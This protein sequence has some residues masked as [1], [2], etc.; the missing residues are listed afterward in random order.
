MMPQGTRRH[1]WKGA[2][3]LRKYFETFLEVAGVKTSF[4]K[5]L[6][7]HSQGVEDS[8]N[9]PTTEMLLEEYLKATDRLTILSSDEE[10]VGSTVQLQKQVAELKEKSKEENWE[11]EQQRKQLQDMAREFAEMKAYL[12]RMDAT[13][14]G[15]ASRSGEDGLTIR[16][17]QVR[18]GEIPPLRP[19][20][21]ETVST[22]GMTPEL[23]KVMFTP[24]SELGG[25]EASKKK[26]EEKGKKAKEEKKKEAAQRENNA[27]PLPDDE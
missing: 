27:V 16:K 10:D 21:T 25:E 15:F 13:V 19:I 6:M 14:R 18:L 26:E 22:E 1:E 12:S 17:L 4:V 11:A 24:W 20:D 8:Y 2:H 3:G 7:A 9:K 5:I 23:L